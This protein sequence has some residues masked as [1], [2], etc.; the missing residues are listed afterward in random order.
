MADNLEIK[1]KASI[2]AANSAKSIGELR[3]SLKDLVSLSGQVG[4]GAGFKKL[5]QAIND[6]EGKLGD[7]NDSFNTLKG[8]GVERLTSSFGL[9]K[10]GFL[11]F[12]SDKIGT[13]F[14]GV[15]AAM[16]AI[17]IFLLIE[18]VKALIDNFD[19]V[20]DV[21]KSFTAEAQTQAKTLRELNSNLGEVAANLEEIAF[22]EEAYIRNSEQRTKLAI[23]AAKQRGATEQEINKIETEGNKKKLEI[24]SQAEKN[25]RKQKEF[26]DNEY[27]R[28]LES[29][30]EEQIKKNEEL[31]KQAES[32]YKESKK[33]TLEADNDLAVKL[34][35]N[36]TKI[37]QD[38]KEAQKKALEEFKKHQKELYDAYIAARDKATDS[39]R[40]AGKIIQDIEAANAKKLQDERNKADAIEFAK[41][42]N[43][44]AERKALLNL[45]LQDRID[46]LTKTKEAVLTNTELTES[47]RTAVIRKY[48]ED[49][50]KLREQELKDSVDKINKYGQV[51]V[52]ITNQVFAAVQAFADL[53]AQKRDQE[54]AAIQSAADQQV[55]GLE[56]QKE[57]EL[58]V[59][60]LSSEQKNA[61]QQEYALKEYQVKL[62]AY[63]KETELKKKSF[64]TDKKLRIVQTV[65]NTI[66]GAVSALTGALQSLPYPAGLIAGLISA[67]AVTALG[68]AQ[69]LKIKNQQFDAGTPPT[70]PSGAGAGISG[71]AGSA[72]P[73][74]GQ[75]F[76]KDVVGQAS[77]AATSAAERT[78]Q[79]Q[80]AQ[81]V[82]VTETDITNTQN[83]V[84][85]IETKATIG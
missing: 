25:Y 62:A 40:E 15:G 74:P 75:N 4:D 3:K 19:V 67:A 32:T 82:Y 28:A 31:L 50:K 79:S 45:T 59:E 13:A 42:L 72:N 64:E 34:A 26:L 33:K 69:V 8:S 83:K 70:P 9:L 85:T 58:A 41:E 55:A 12:D 46:E 66:T 71:G 76:N 77:S 68:V 52:Q 84:K 16:S 10:E 43:K 2:D 27:I 20:V 14:K 1:I 23:E 49:V 38:Q 65:I 78:D 17:P 51:A 63:N 80:G 21:F 54:A 60:G 35:E 30:D 18:G 24:L 36:Q 48:N 73:N 6:T 56:A 44:R 37:I 39:T 61:I 57:A 81:R 7:L 29:G 47:Q 53:A 5:S 22:K 11:S